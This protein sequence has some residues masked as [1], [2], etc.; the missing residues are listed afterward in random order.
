[1]EGGYFSKI[2]ISAMQTVGTKT[3]TCS[4]QNTWTVE[5]LLGGAAARCLVHSVLS[6]VEWE[7]LHVTGSWRFDI[8]IIIIIIIV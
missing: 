2:T 6:C 4:V 5:L 1:M 3:T 7:L 8:V